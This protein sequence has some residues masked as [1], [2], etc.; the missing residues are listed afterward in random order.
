MLDDLFAGR[1]RTLVD[2]VI[3]RPLLR[4]GEHGVRVACRTDLER[5]TGELGLRVDLAEVAPAH[6]LADAGADGL[7]S[8]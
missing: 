7:H 6:G 8:S 4:Q 2:G 5:A 3:G 1:R